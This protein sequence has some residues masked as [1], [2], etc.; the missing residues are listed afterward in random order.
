MILCYL[1]C[2][3]FVLVLEVCQTF[4]EFFELEKKLFSEWDVSDE[5]WKCPVNG[6]CGSRKINRL[7][8]KSAKHKQYATS[9]GLYARCCQ[10]SAHPTTGLWKLCEKSLMKWWYLFA[11]TIALEVTNVKLEFDRCLFCSQFIVKKTNPTRKIMAQGA[12]ILKRF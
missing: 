3:C 6:C 8:M 9:G 4:S 7:A 10:N 12:L 11:V 5:M 1:L 2:C